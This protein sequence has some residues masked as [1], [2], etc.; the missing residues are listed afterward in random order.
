MRRPGG[1]TPA[2]N[3][4]AS[5]SGESS[6][7]QHRRQTGKMPFWTSRRRISTYVSPFQ[8]SSSVELARSPTSTRM[9][10]QKVHL[11]RKRDARVQER[12]EAAPL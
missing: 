9:N 3:G 11:P 7:L 8:I 10:G 6:T 2:P 1:S 5:G 4:S 12:I